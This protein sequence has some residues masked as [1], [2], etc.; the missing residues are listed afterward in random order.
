MTT[1]VLGV[2]RHAKAGVRAEDLVSL[3]DEKGICAGIYQRRLHRK[4]ACTPDNAAH[5]HIG[6]CHCQNGLFS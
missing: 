2:D 6:Y 3:F 5:T 1:Y 4:C